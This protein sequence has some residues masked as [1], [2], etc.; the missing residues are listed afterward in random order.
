M[1][2]RLVSLSVSIGIISL[3]ASCNKSESPNMDSSSDVSS[4]ELSVEHSQQYLV[5]IDSSV[6][7]NDRVAAAKQLAEVEREQLQLALLTLLLGRYDKITLDNV[8]LLGEI[9]DAQS[10]VLLTK[11]FPDSDKCP[12]KL[13]TAITRAVEKIERRNP[14]Q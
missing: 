11:S 13:H 1:N 10:A 4:P 12:G 5:S 8:C 7:I 14:L 6:H 3:V 9:G 2:I